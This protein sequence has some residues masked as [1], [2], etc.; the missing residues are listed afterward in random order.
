MAA[1][2]G[3]KYPSVHFEAKAAV[4]GVIKEALLPALIKAGYTGPA[5]THHP[6]PPAIGNDPLSY[7]RRV[8]RVCRVSWGI[9]CGVPHPPKAST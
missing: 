3:A 2:Y 9:I 4:C 6:A 8:C 1:Y 7:L 5:G